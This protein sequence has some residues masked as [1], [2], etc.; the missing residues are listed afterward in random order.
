MRVVVVSAIVVVVVVVVGG[1]L[2]VVV[3]D[4]TGT[5]LEV[6]VEGVDND[7]HAVAIS[8]VAKRGRRI[9]IAAGLWHG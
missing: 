3:D 5:E 2:V 1:T 6:V 8:S 9:D 4:V 7:V